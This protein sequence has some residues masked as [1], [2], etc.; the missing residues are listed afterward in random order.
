MLA[1][2]RDGGLG[3]FGPGA[4]LGRQWRISVGKT[5]SHQFWLSVWVLW[6]SV[7]Q[8]K[9]P[10]RSSMGNLTHRSQ[11]YMQKQRVDITGGASAPH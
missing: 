10:R 11:R 9:W 4:S 1:E 5:P 7:C 3:K 2:G 8:R 6:G